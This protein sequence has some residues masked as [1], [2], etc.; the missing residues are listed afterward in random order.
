[1]AVEDLENIAEYIAK[2][3]EYYAADF[4]ERIITQVG[5]LESFANIGRK[6]PEQNDDNVR[7][8][9]YHNYR[10]V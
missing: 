4:V 5:K 7:E 6:V 2:D 3:S 10:L 8:I 1:M 9:I